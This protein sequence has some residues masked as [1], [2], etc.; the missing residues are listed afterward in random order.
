MKAIVITSFGG[1][2]VLKIQERPDPI[3]QKHE[4]LIRVKAAGINRPDVFQRKGNYPAPEGVAADIPG[5]EV[6]GIVEALGAEATNFKVGDEVM[7]LLAGGGYAELVVVNE[8]MCMA[9]PSNVSFVE[10]AGLPETLFTVWH[11]VFQRG[12]LQSGENFL[13]HGGAGGIG[14]TAIQLAKAFGAHVYT[15]VGSIDKKLLTEGLG[16]T[17]AVIYKDEDFVEALADIGMDVIL[18][19]IGGEYFAKNI[20]IMNPDGRL[21]YI[22]AM[23]GAKVELNL[24]KLMQKRISLTGSTLRAR[25]IAFKSSLAQEVEEKVI[26]LIANGTFKVEVSQVFD[27][28]NAEEAHRQI[29]RKDHFGKI[30]L[31]FEG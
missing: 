9:K 16:A 27:Y 29:E 25:D 28:R 5:L 7:A 18:D 15:T 11:N 21:V 12:K 2:K 13:V 10:A 24:L 23:Q 6:S 20:K 1:P 26:P 4:L 3:P 31:S 17:K 30:I 8:G 14:T 19:S 22:N